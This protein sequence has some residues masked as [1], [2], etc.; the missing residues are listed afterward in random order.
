MAKILYAITHQ[1]EDGT[2]RSLI[3]EIFR[4]SQDILRSSSNNC[5]SEGVNPAVRGN[6]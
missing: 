3:G 5:R 6:S 1:D 2:R 4:L